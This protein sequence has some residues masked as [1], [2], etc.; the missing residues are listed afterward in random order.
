M[1]FKDI[2]DGTDMNNWTNVKLFYA[3]LIQSGGW[4]NMIFAGYNFEYVL[5]KKE[6]QFK[7]ASNRKLI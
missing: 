4:W 2:I 6:K 1:F 5:T 7:K 3:E